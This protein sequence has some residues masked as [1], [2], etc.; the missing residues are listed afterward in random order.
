[1]TFKRFLVFITLFFFNLLSYTFSQIPQYP[2]ITTNYTDNQIFSNLIEAINE[3]CIAVGTNNVNIIEWVETRQLT[4][5]VETVY[6]IF[7]DKGTNTP[8]YIWD[9]I[10]DITTKDT[11]SKCTTFNDGKDITTWVKYPIYNWIV[12]DGIGDKIIYNA[13]EEWNFVSADAVKDSFISALPDNTIYITNFPFTYSFDYVTTNIFWSISNSVS[14]ITSNNLVLIDDK[15]KEL[16]PYFLMSLPQFLNGP[17]KLYQEW[18]YQSNVTII[19]GPPVD[20]AVTNFIDYFPYITYPNMFYH[21][22]LGT[23]KN[24]LADNNWGYVTSCTPYWVSMVH[25]NFKFLLAEYTYFSNSWEKVYENGSNSIG[26]ASH[27]FFKYF[28]NESNIFP[29]IEYKINNTNIPF[30]S[31]IVNIRGNFMI[32]W[33]D[34]LL[35]SDLGGTNFSE[36]LIMSTNIDFTRL[37]WTSIYSN[38]IGKGID[39]TTGNTGD[40]I[41]IYWDINNYKSYLNA[42]TDNYPPFLS[43]TNLQERMNYIRNMQY[44]ELPFYYSKGTVI[45]SAYFK[46]NNN[47]YSEMDFEPEMRRAWYDLD[48]NLHVCDG[49]DEGCF[50]DTI[51]PEEGDPYLDLAPWPFGYLGEIPTGEAGAGLYL[52]PWE[53]WSKWI[54]MSDPPYFFTNTIYENVINTYNVP[55]YP[56]EEFTIRPTLIGSKD[57]HAFVRW[58]WYYDAPWTQTDW[59]EALL[60]YVTGID[61]VAESYGPVWGDFDGEGNNDKDKIDYAYETNDIFTIIA[62]P[63]VTNLSTNFFCT[64]DFYGLFTNDENEVSYTNQYYT[65]LGTIFKNDDKDHIESP[66][67]IDPNDWFTPFLNLIGESRYHVASE[68]GPT[69]GQR[70]SKTI[71]GSNTYPCNY[72]D[73]LYVGQYSVDPLYDVDVNWGETNIQYITNYEYIVVT[74]GDDTWFTAREIIEENHQYGPISFT[75]D[76]TY[77]TNVTLYGPCGTDWLT[78][79][80]VELVQDP[81]SLPATNESPYIWMTN[82]NVVDFFGVP[83]TNEYRYQYYFYGNQE[84]F[85]GVTNYLDITYPFG[86]NLTFDWYYVTNGYENLQFKYDTLFESWQKTDASI[87]YDFYIKE[88]KAVVKYNFKYQ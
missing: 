4:S 79:L 37:P 18:L 43:R 12:I 10:E 76:A 67:A 41:L 87:N 30:S 56:G 35:A 44:I 9:I 49:Y 61:D 3:R 60:Q 14:F 64:I 36:S 21:A 47:Y 62:Y 13:F 34:Q 86:T 16:A 84:L 42:N 31:K 20:T 29:T 68:D 2:T 72:N 24:I 8:D 45:E 46:S 74:V 33:E 65:Y 69:F 28:F 17:D 73:T 39:C 38:G 66:T 57:F 32:D 82:Y 80:G 58:G 5:S 27:P 77:Q 15:I 81:I 6:Q 54:T 19:P 53:N 55:P 85:K 40:T 71:I 23:N 52:P 26:M 50:P 22:N 78:Y 7:I 11:T 88:W 25:D 83:V 51:I 59:S 63:F 70:Y 75:N 1:M 48:N